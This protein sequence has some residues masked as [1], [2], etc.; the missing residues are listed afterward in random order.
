MARWPKYQ[1]SEEHRRQVMT[2]AGFGIPQQEIAR[3]IDISD[4]TLRTHY[5]RELDTGA[6]EANVRVAQSLYNM[7]VRDKIPAAA[8][9]WTKARMGWREPPRDVIVGG[10][11]DRPLAIS[12]VVRA[13]SPVS[14][15]SEWLTRYAPSET[16]IDGEAVEQP[17]EPL[18]KKLPPR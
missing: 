17:A 10:D 2:L 4:R 18:Q 12:Y 1:A 8:I 6:T 13:P 16:Q 3:L 7:A 14:S 15:A 5:R 9:W 11:E